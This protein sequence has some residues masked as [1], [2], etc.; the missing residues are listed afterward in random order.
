[1]IRRCNGTDPNLL[2]MGGKVP[3]G[4][5]L[6]FDDVER[7]VIYPHRLIHGGRRPG[8]SRLRLVK[9]KVELEVKGVGP[10]LS[11]MKAK[12]E[13]LSPEDKTK[14]LQGLS[15][16]MRRWGVT[17]EEIDPEIAKELETPKGEQVH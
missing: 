4:C 7:E 5:G 11:A 3:C 15:D 8:T 16:A 2:G 12:M 9:G 6:E 1:M 13:R 17:V 14:L 10:V